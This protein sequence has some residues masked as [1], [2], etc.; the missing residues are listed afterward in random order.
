MAIDGSYVSRRK[1]SARI[2][3]REKVGCVPKVSAVLTRLMF[4][5]H[6]TL[7]LWRISE[8]YEPVYLYAL[9]VGLGCLVL[10]MVFTLAVRQGKEYKWFCPSVFF[11]LLSVVPSLWF[12]Q[13]AQ[14][15]YYDNTSLHDGGCLAIVD[16]NVTISPPMTQIEN[17]SDVTAAWKSN[18]DVNRYKRDVTEASGNNKEKRRKRKR[19]LRRK[20][21]LR[22][23]TYVINATTAGYTSDY[24]VINTRTEL[25][26]VTSLNP[27]VVTKSEN[28][29]S[30]TTGVGNERTI[31]MTQFLLTTTT[32]EREN[33]GFVDVTRRKLN[34]F[35]NVVNNA[36]RTVDELLHKLD[37]E[38]WLLALHQVLLFVLVIGRW[39][40]P[41]GEITREQLSQLL[42]VFI[43]VGA[44]ILEFVTETIDNDVKQVQ[45]NRLLHYIIYAVWSWSLLQFTL[46]LTAA[47]SR[48]T[49]VGFS[50]G[51]RV[52]IV[53]DNSNC[54]A[55]SIFNDADL[56]GILA[57]LLLQD[58]PFLAFRLYM[59][60]VY[61][62]IHQMMVFFTGKNALVVILQLYRIVVLQIEHNKKKPDSAT[63]SE[64]QPLKGT[65]ERL[66]RTSVEGRGVVA[67][68]ISNATFKAK[69]N[70][71]VVVKI[72]LENESKARTRRKGTI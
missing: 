14:M 6:A 11:Y 31:E 22:T 42:L 39:L 13:I 70:G 35:S 45:C 8:L 32:R 43:G 59:M 27:D 46:V 55:R 12:L 25:P 51:E 4:I 48:K 30:M 29:V 24:D 18:N 47:K 38:Q 33:H 54:C 7:A 1:S 44:D 9:S 10:E 28:D 41:K 62:Q 36:T 53:Q 5:L 49:R 58:L 67:G 16:I 34:E 56:W 21:R 60:I 37:P 19:K 15:D 66:A 2:K 17:V 23:T 50:N 26:I 72:R 65:L 40:L 20:Q 52:A 61:N 57:T 64:L 3:K 71:S 69:R 68:D 63:Q